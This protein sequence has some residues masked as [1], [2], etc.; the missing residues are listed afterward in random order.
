M[1][2]S[3]RPVYFLHIA[4]CGGTTVR[5]CIDNLYNKEEIF[6]HYFTSDL[7]YPGV[8]DPSGY[9]LYRGHFGLAL[10]QNRAVPERMFTWLREPVDRILST[11]YFYRQMGTLDASISLSGWL[12]NLDRLENGCWPMIGWLIYGSVRLE[13][14]YSETFV[15]ESWQAVR[16]GSHDGLIEQAKKIVNQ[17]FLIGLQHRFES[18][19]NVLHYHLGSYPMLIHEPQNKNPIRPVKFDMTALSKQ[20]RDGLRYEAELDR[21]VYQH[22]IDQFSNQYQTMTGELGIGDASGGCNDEEQVV[23]KMAKIDLLVLPFH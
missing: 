6:P 19:M 23:R 4:K 8:S 22:G 3:T 20:A 14:L 1:N 7:H 9:G 11:Y 5:L 16:S 15:K 10:W 17:C 13:R 12:E 2:I 18:S 21:E